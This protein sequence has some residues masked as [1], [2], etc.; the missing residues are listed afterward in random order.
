M[1]K[2]APAVEWSLAWSTA[3]SPWI[4]S[5]CDA[6]QFPATYALKIE[7][8]GIAATGWPG[9]SAGTP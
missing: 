4:T 6:C 7:P 5:P 2:I 9:R 8:G 3:A 1:A